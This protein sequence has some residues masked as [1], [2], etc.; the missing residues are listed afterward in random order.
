MS[1]NISSF[2]DFLGNRLVV[3]KLFSILEMNSFVNSLFL[4]SSLHGV[5]VESVFRLSDGFWFAYIIHSRIKLIC[6]L[7]IFFVFYVLIMCFCW[8]QNLGLIV[9]D[10]MIFMYAVK[11]YF[12]V[13]VYF[14]SYTL[15]VAILHHIGSFCTLHDLLNS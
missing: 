1:W 3:V 9:W 10:D 15:V 14:C 8:L 12:V 13:W 11:C 5:V 2:C 7:T 6:S 4:S